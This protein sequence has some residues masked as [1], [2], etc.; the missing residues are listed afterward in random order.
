[1]KNKYIRVITISVLLLV[2]AAMVWDVDRDVSESEN[3]KLQQLPT[4]SVENVLSG[5]YMER[6]ET[7]LTDQFPF[8]D[9]AMVTKTSFIKLLGSRQVGDVII[10][11][12]GYLMK[13]ESD[14]DK[15]HYLELL[16]SVDEFAKSQGE[17]VSTSLMLVPGASAIYEDKLPYGLKSKCGEILDTAR[18]TLTSAYFIDLY[19]PLKN[20]AVAEASDKAGAAAGEGVFYRTDH[21]WTTYGALIGIKVYEECFDTAV[22]EESYKMLPVTGSF[23]GTLASSCGVYSEYDEISIG[24]PIKEYEYVVSYV[25]EMRKSTSLFEAEALDKKD[26]Y[27]VFQGGNYARVDVNIVNDTGRN[28]VI[29][30]DSYA[31]CMLSMLMPF[32]DSIIVIDPRYF[33]GDIEQ[34][35]KS[36]E[37]TEVLFVYSVDSFVKDTSLEDII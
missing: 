34:I 36:K 16:N 7:Y 19:E 4:P 3:R 31:N 21:H 14:Y 8:R 28:L 11:S 13:A 18:Q 10:C 33:Y 1:M 5:D 2:L 35:I 22:S 9:A 37:A 20:A 27:L 26:K 6:F 32:Y 24:V 15:E 30:K 29:I 25:N 23:Q 12:D 17:G